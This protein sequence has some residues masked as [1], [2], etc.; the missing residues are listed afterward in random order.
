MKQNILGADPGAAAG[1][2]GES[3]PAEEVASTGAV[4]DPAAVPPEVAPPTRGTALIAAVLPTLPGAPGV[5]RMLDGKGNVLYVGKARS[6]KK[7]V[8]SYLQAPRLSP[9]LHRMVADTQAME[10]VTTHTEAEALLL[11]ANLI[12]RLKPRYNILLR[13]DKSFPSILVTADHPFP[14]VLKHRGAQARPGSY[15]GP[16]ASGWAV[17]KTLATLQRAFLL[18]T[19]SDGIFAARTRPCLLHQIKRCAAPCVGYIDEAAYG[20]LVGEAR[21]FL[22]G[23]SRRIQEDLARRMEEASRGLDFEEAA[24]LR[25]RIRALTAVQAHQEVNLDGLGDADVFALHQAGGAACVQAFFFR[26]GCNYGTRAYFPDR[27]A[28]EEPGAVLE[29]FLTQ[30]YADREPPPCILISHPTPEPALVAEALSVRA[31]RKVTLAVPQRGAKLQLVRNAGD[32]A[33]DALA[34]RL[35]ESASQQRLLAEVAKLFGLDGP[36]RRIEVY[37]NSHVRGSDPYGAMIVA[38]PEGWIKNAYRKFIIRGDIAP[39]DDYAMMREVLRRR[40][41]R[42][43]TQDPER[44]SGDW[45]DLVL[46]D[47]GAGQLQAAR[48]VLADLGIGVG[49]GVGAGGVALAAIAKGP[50]RDAGRER[51]FRPDREPLSPDPRDPVLYFLQRLRDE[52][53]RFAIGTHRAKRSVGLVRS[54]LD[55]IPSIGASRKK[56]LLH[57]FGSAKAVAAAGI[58][59]LETAPGISRSIARKIYDWFHAGQ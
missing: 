57:H 21:A 41:A 36:P 58:A 32:N 9:R 14:Q 24:K 25:D 1:Q 47:G 4:P 13:D 38:G 7:R 49:T 8:A 27:A 2:E 40:F 59:D 3:A 6:L 46:I 29:A 34:R 10:F 20:A 42:A 5:Y 51:I 15:F 22:S 17:N 33:R 30:F 11:E 53:H 31:G 52:A 55:E 23:D 19:C 39:G 43:I 35:A 26:G 44:T 48:Q 18:R 16:F 56:A 28:G 37:D 12:K 50:Q 54:A 45:P